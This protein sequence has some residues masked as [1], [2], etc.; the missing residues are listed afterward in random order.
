VFLVLNAE[1]AGIAS[2]LMDQ[3][4]VTENV[5]WDQKYTSE[6][7][8]TMQLV[9]MILAIFLLTAILIG[10]CMVAGVLFFLSRRL[11][12]KFFPDSQ[13]GHTDEDQLIRLNLK[14]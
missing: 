7:T 3:F 13:W 9:H 2:A 4:E 14:T 12:A 8:F 6:R 11:A 5:S 1:N 10:S